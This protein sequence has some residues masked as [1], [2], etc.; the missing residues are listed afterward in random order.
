MII[1]LKMKRTKQE[2]GEDI[3]IFMFYLYI[4][5][6]FEIGYFYILF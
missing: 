1:R 5:T 3:H 4:L 2:E 6:D